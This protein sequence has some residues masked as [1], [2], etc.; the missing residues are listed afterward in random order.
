MS[1]ILLYSIPGFLALLTLELL[2]TRCAG[3]R[4]GVRGY[5]LGDTVHTFNPFRIVSHEPAAVLRELARARSWS[6]RLR[7][8]F[9]RPSDAA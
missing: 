1:N 6:E 2:W 4:E 7:L 9:G 3:V 5:E 8:V